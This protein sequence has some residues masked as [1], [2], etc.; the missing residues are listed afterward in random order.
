MIYSRLNFNTL[1]FFLK[2]LGVSLASAMA[3]IMLYR[4][5]DTLDDVL[6]FQGSRFTVISYYLS[7]V[8]SIIQNQLPLI[9]LFSATFTCA[10]IKLNN[11]HFPVW[12]SGNSFFAICKYLFSFG[13]SGSL[14]F[15]FLLIF[16]LFP[17][18]VGKLNY[19]GKSEVKSVQIA[20]IAISNTM[21][22]CMKKIIFTFFLP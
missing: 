13:L 14:L 10:N 5:T 7:L 15:F 4:V 12:S 6:S 2:S 21:F 9:F 22:I 18:K 20:P 1:N 19:T 3:I 11:E 8:P 16:W 17:Q